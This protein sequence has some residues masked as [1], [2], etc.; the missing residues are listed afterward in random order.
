[1]SVFPAVARLLYGHAFVAAH[2]S[3]ALRDAFYDF[4]ETFELAASPVPHFLQRRFCRARHFLLTAFRR[5]WQRQSPDDTL[6]PPAGLQP[7]R[8]FKQHSQQL[9][10]VLVACTPQQENGCV[11]AVSGGRAL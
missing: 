3:A 9:Q 10:R 5:D 2:G 4:E 11:Q 1:M 7:H 6:N 8:S